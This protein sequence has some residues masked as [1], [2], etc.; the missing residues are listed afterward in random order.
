MLPPTKLNSTCL[1][2]EPRTLV[3]H[4]KF[5]FQQISQHHTG[6]QDKEMGLALPVN[7]NFNAKKLRDPRSFFAPVGR[8]IHVFQ[9]QRGI[10]K[11]FLCKQSTETPNNTQ[12]SFI[13]PIIFVQQFL[14]SERNSLVVLVHSK[15]F[16]NRSV[17]VRHHVSH[18]SG[19]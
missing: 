2:L 14:E 6:E 10:F 13:V 16:S 1:C 11:A 3:L 18:R 7:A 12:A 4:S 17:F 15:I 8:E 9:M 19:Y 5:E